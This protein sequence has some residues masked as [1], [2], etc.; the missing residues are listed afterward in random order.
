MGMIYLNCISFNHN[1]PRGVCKS[2]HM[3]LCVSDKRRGDWWI[4]QGVSLSKAS[5]GAD[6][7]SDMPPI[8]PKS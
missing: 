7:A 6:V 4:V 2:Q 5:V 3:Q 1:A 8:L